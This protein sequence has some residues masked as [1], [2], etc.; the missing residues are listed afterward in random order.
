M[1]EK[2]FPL[3]PRRNYSSLYV[4]G[5]RYGITFLLFQGRSSKKEQFSHTLRKTHL[6]P[7]IERRT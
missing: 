5:V 6:N 3:V 2:F 4:S 7:Q 1:P